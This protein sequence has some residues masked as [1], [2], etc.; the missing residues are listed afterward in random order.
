MDRLATLAT[1]FSDIEVDYMK[2]TSSFVPTTVP[3]TIQ[4]N[5]ASIT[6]VLSVVD[7]RQESLYNALS[8]IPESSSWE[9]VN[10]LVQ[11]QATLNFYSLLESIATETNTASRM[12]L[13][14]EAARASSVMNEILDE[15]AILEAYHYSLGG[16]SA[17]LAVNIVLFILM[18]T[19]SVFYRQWWFLVT[20]GLGLGLEI[21]GYIGRVIL[22]H[23][24]NNFSAYIMS[25]I[26]LSMGP[27][28]LMA[29]IYYIA[30]QLTIIYGEQFSV[31][32]PRKYLS[33][34]NTANVISVALQGTG[35][36]IA[37][38]AQQ[39]QDG[40]TGHNI[41]VAGIAIQVCVIG[42][43]DILWY[44]LL[45][46]LYTEYK[47][48]GSS[49]FN[50][51]FQHV[52][53]RNLLVPFMIGVSIS[54]ILILVRFIYKAIELKQGF[55]SKLAYEEIYFMIFEGLLISLGSAILCIL[56]PGFVYGKDAHIRVDRSWRKFTFRKKR[57][58]DD[59]EL[60][61]SDDDAN[62][63]AY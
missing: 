30:A 23:N 2:L 11:N 38:G 26:L 63:Y 58:E 22:S 1:Q 48:Y 17:L 59:Y 25:S 57:I 28:F 12:S 37:A 21:V 32:L 24:T 40:K 47:T 61:A 35:R 20:W 39:S 18:F 29:G 46:R 54:C 45:Y 16:N 60:R 62:E 43:F 19:S 14:T 33:I 4:Q 13:M 8:T 49:R 5:I 27:S 53:E 7:S 10:D 3:T 44:T 42:V 52:R 36:G 50:P 6:S 34:F 31:L 55:D 15:N 51:N 41:L 9:Y 56:S